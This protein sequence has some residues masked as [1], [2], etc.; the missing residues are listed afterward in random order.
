MNEKMPLSLVHGYIFR[1]QQSKEAHAKMYEQGACPFEPL[2][3][4]QRRW[5]EER[6][7][8]LQDMKIQ[9]AQSGI[10]TVTHRFVETLFWM[11]RVKGIL[12]CTIS[13][14]TDKG[15]PRYSGFLEQSFF[16]CTNECIHITQLCCRPEC[17][18]FRAVSTV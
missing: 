16:L 15:N 18:S 17:A 12:D 9:E 10:Q 13:R 2:W 4:V 7:P 14:W 3:V 1:E 11:G 6:Q 8:G 5:S